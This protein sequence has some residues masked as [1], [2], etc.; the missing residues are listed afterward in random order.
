MS[1]QVRLQPAELLAPR[2]ALIP[3]QENYFL[4]GS[5]V[6][7]RV[8]VIAAVTENPFFTVDEADF[9]F[10]GNYALETRPRCRR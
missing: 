7:Q 9:G 1:H 4:E 10:S 6:R 3:Q 8:N 2:Q 5:V